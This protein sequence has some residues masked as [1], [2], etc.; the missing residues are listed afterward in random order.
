MRNK[1]II[2]RLIS[3]PKE[4]LKDLK[5]VFSHKPSSH[6]VAHIFKS[7]E[8]SWK[9]HLDDALTVLR[10]IMQFSPIRRESLSETSREMTAKMAQFKTF[11]H[12]EASRGPMSC[13]KNKWKRRVELRRD[14][15]LMQRPN[16]NSNK[17]FSRQNNR[18]LKRIIDDEL[19]VCLDCGLS[20]HWRE[21]FIRQNPSFA[22]KK[23]RKGKR[24]AFSQGQ[25][26]FHR[27]S[28]SKFDSRAWLRSVEPT[29][30]SLLEQKTI[31][32]FTMVVAPGVLA[33]SNLLKRF[34]MHLVFSLG[35]VNWTASSFCTDKEEIAVMQ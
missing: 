13:N 6:S 32:Q 23:S 24:Q 20:G 30:M 10:N 11:M 3:E 17:P 35:F 18:G 14:K 5:T 12:Y 34:A 1:D 4:N 15:K 22:T 27:G 31:I 16:L 25:P 9:T 29:Q 33:E 8:S 2:F 19:D 26:D 7:S 21:D 28:R